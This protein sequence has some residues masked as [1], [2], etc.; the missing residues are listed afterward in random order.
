MSKRDY[1]EV[2]GA[3]KTASKAEIK[4]AYRK[5]AMKYHP[6][7]NQSD[8]GVEAKFKEV[9]EAYS[10]LK[11]EQ[12]RAAY[13]QFGHAGVDPSAG[14]G[15]GPGG[16]GFGDIFGDM[17]GD[18]FGGGGGRRQARGSDLRIR[19]ELTLEEAVDGVEKKIRV[20]RMSACKTCDGSG[21]KA[22]TQ[23]S[24]C[25]TCNG[26]G[27]VRMQQGFFSVQQAC[28]QCRGTGKQINDPCTDC[29][30]QG[31][32][33]EEKTLKVKIPAGVDDGDQVRLGGEGEG[34][35]AGVVP[36]DL[37]VQVQLKEHE[38]FQRDGDDLNCD[39]PVSYITMALGGELEVPTLSGRASIKIPA[40]TQSSRI[41]R[42]RGKGVKNVRSSQVGDLYI[43]VLTETPVH[44]SSE[45][46]G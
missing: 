17:F 21:A 14:M 36:G 12:K 46:K 1:Y 5:M 31:Q 35:G 11:D 30:G 32:T 4:K 3:S 19:V 23:P 27:Q 22:G 43:K 38:I 9:Q 33:R 7:R 2:L 34:G 13:D 15:G 39:V 42:L 18:I 25:S 37:Y 10:V 41:F 16:A 44:L 8:D 26:Q 20:P 24:S 45:Q 28:P 6:D 29:S 40:G